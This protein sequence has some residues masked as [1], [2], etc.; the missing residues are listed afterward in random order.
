MRAITSLS[1][2]S[3]WKHPALRWMQ[4]VTTM[5]REARRTTAQFLNGL[6]VAVLAT[7][8]IGPMASD[9][10]SMAVLVVS[11]LTGG[12]LHALAIVLVNRSKG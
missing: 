9:K 7:G 1:P 10:I 5:K 11:I 2:F 3:P 6:A 8:A 12:A 4:E